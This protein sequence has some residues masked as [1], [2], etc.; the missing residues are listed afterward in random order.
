MAFVAINRD[1][2]ECRVFVRLLNV[3]GVQSCN[4]HNVSSPSAEIRV[5]HAPCECILLRFANVIG[6]LE[7]AT[8]TGTVLVEIQ[9]RSLVKSVR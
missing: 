7:S 2:T 1:G 8:L 5:I 4:G 9:I 6:Y 3:Y